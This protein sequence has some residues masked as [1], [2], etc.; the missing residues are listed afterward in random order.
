MIRTDE[1]LEPLKYYESGLKDLHHDNVVA[2]FEQLT[3]DS[4]VD[5]EENK[6]TCR[7]YYTKKQALGKLKNKLGLFKFLTFLC[8]FFFIAGVAGGIV[9][10]FV[11]GMDK[12]ISIPVGVALIV[13]GIGLLV[14]DI[15]VIRKKRKSL[16]EQ[17]DKLE[18]EVEELL[19]LAWSQMAPLNNLFDELMAPHLFTKSAPLIQIDDKLSSLT[20][21]R[22][23]NQFNCSLDESTARSTLVVQSGNINTNPFIL[24]Q[25]LVMDMVPHVYTGSLVITYTRTVSDGNG[26]HRTVT[27]TQTLHASIT[28]PKPEYSVETSLVFY[29][30]AGSN[31]S[32]SRTPAGMVGKSE[33]E[34]NR[35]AEKKD[36]DETRLAEKAVREG[37]TY[38]KFANAKFNA[39]MNQKGRDHELEYRLL[40]TPLAQQNYCYLFSKQDDIYYTKNKCAN[41]IM[42]AHDSGKDYSGSP[43]NYYSFDYEV[44]T[45][46]F[47]NYNMTFFE[48]IYFDLLPILSIP[49]FHENQ[50]EPYIASKTRVDEL[51]FYEGEVIANRFEPNLF[52]PRG[53]DTDVILKVNPRGEDLTVMAY[54]FHADPRVE[55]VP[56][57]GND[58]R[59]HAVP[60][61]YY[62]YLPVDGVNLVKV[63]NKGTKTLDKNSNSVI[64]YKMFDA[65]FIN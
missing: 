4:K 45:K 40:F 9:L 50:S 65:Q 48:G 34:V 1:Y 25:V 11:D 29:S 62:E 28:R 51:S 31:L 15:L 27:E 43:T 60:V 32:F 17:I 21:E 49:I 23:V 56:V 57:V 58:G 8:I 46:N 63:F 52:K 19:R 6:E 13:V 36:K 30:D 22:I 53:C 12:G 3:K 54:G 35:I 2:F 39:Y 64:N 16:K 14:L 37:K 61:H 24:R 10:F 7:K 47:V 59:T 18:M 42:S 38:T 5:I 33:K 20:E 55:M 41:I 26:G 44:I